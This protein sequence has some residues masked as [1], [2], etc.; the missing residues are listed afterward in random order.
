MVSNISDLFFFFKIFA[1]SPHACQWLQLKAA[2]GLDIP[3]IGHVELDVQVLGKVIPKRWI[4]VVQSSQTP[5][6]TTCVPGV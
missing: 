2:N 1:E 4:L 5:L 6:P 3:Y